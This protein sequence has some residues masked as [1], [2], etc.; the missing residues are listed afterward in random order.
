MRLK[1]SFAAIAFAAL[2]AIPVTAAI[3]AMITITPIP[4]IHFQRI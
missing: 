2:L 4:A 1:S 3:K